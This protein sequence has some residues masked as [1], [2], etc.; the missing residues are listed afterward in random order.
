MLQCVR[1][2]VP[3]EQR[4]LEVQ[5]SRAESRRHR[6]VRYRVEFLDRFP[7]PVKSAEQVRFRLPELRNEDLRAL[8]VHGDLHSLGCSSEGFIR[9][10]LFAPQA[11]ELPHE[12]R[13]GFCLV[14]GELYEQRV[15]VIPA[16]LG[17][18]QPIEL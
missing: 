16:P 15:R 1:R 14:F 10:S 18:V 13:L 7:I 12:P 8:V 17:I 6:H 4:P 3:F 11:C 2:I 5:E 9:S